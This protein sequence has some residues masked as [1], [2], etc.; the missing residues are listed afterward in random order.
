MLD[1][2]PLAEL[3][4]ADVPWRSLHENVASGLVQAVT[5]SATD[6]ETGNTVVF[7]EGRARGRD[8]L[9]IGRASGRERV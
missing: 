1:P 4:R 3:V 6:V 5:V 9:E 7:L 2:G 8:P